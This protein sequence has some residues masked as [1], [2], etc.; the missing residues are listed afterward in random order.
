MDEVVAASREKPRIW[1]S[2]LS[3]VSA[4]ALLLAGASVCGVTAHSVAQR[5]PEIAVRM[6]LGA[7]LRDIMRLVMHRATPLLAMGV[8]AGA[9]TAWLLTGLMSPL[10]FGL[11]AR[12]PLVFVA[13]TG[14]VLAAGLLASY[15]PARRAAQ[16]APAD[17]LRPS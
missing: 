4:L 9:V 11:S 8:T 13:A 16:V 6:A 17:A 3:G 2:V 15:L 1:T 5:A 14:V 12:E 10:V 7:A